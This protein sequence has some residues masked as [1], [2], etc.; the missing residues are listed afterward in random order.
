MDNSNP[1]ESNA[2]NKNNEQSAASRSRRK[3]IDRRDPESAKESKERERRGV[4][5]RR[6]K[7]RK[8]KAKNKKQN[9]DQ[10][11]LRL[12]QHRKKKLLAG[13]EPIM[14]L[15][16]DY[17]AMDDYPSNELVAT[18]KHDRDYWL[19]LCSVFTSGFLFGFTGLVPAWI[20]GASCG[21]AVLCFS[22]VYTPFRKVLFSS[23]P[24][25][26]LLLKRK[27]IEFAA[28][29]HIQFLEG[30]DGLAWRCEKLS[31]YNSNLGRK[32]FLG[33]IHFSRQQVLMDV[34]RN[35]KQIRLY[36]LFMIESQ[37]AYK[38]LQ[39][40]YL[41]NHFTHLDEGWDDALS[42]DEVEQFEREESNDSNSPSG[43]AA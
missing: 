13:C 14:G 29:N 21:A 4:S 22:L 3:V 36:L 33:L 35:R 11:T 10:K 42:E 31:K 1:A 15:N 30:M 12:Q 9:V 25:K 24:L 27:T 37:K 16:Y 2:D 32:L 18:A 6:D 43:A 28:L 23:P 41:D 20:A 38:R 40:D 39:K 26:D 19:A 8:S 5:G 34:I 17:L 7:A